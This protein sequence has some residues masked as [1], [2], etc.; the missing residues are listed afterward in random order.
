MPT[1]NPNIPQKPPSQVR[2]PGFPWLMIVFSAILFGFSLLIYLA[3]AAYSSNLSNQVKKINDSIATKKA[4]IQPDSQ[5]A[6]L[7]VYS[8]VANIQFI[9]NNHVNISNFFKNLQNRTNTQV[10]YTNLSVNPS[11]NEFSLQG[12]A[13]SYEKLAEQLEAFRRDL[14]NIADVNLQS[15]RLT[16]NNN[17]EFSISVRVL[18]GAFQ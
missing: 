14:E 11:R 6:Y 17:V 1:F 15:S 7:D 5:R 4:S 10:R 18:P 2:G 12:A 8:Q 13:A 3:L 9:M 16:Q